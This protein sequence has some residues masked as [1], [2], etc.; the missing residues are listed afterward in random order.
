[1]NL[2]SLLRM[3]DWKWT[4]TAIVAAYGAGLSTYKA[5]ADRTRDKRQIRVTISP[6]YLTHGPNLSG[7][8]L[9]LSASNPG[10]RPVT[11]TSV[12]LQLPDKRTMIIPA[13][14]G[15]AQLP[16]ELNEGNSVTHW[17]PTREVAA[18]LRRAGF[19]RKVRLTAFYLDATDDRHWSESL[20]FDTAHA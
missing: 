19:S 15:T 13:Q 10:H 2:H 3:I 9:I 16:H 17:M 11:L 12:G 7:E 8:M 5:W 18:E 20:L 1:M 6:G 4:V 14:E